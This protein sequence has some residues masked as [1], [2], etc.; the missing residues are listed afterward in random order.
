M[1]THELKS[2]EPFYSAVK[3]GDMTAVVYF[4]DRGFD[5]GDT[6]VLRKWDQHTS[7]YVLSSDEGMVYEETHRCVTHILRGGDYGIEQGYVVLSVR[8]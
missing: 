7:K 4:D 8:P 3:R 6:L 1:A 2:V 5:V